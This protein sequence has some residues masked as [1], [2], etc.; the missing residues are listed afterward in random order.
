MTPQRPVLILVCGLF[1]IG[2]GCGLVLLGGQVAGLTPLAVAMILLGSAILIFWL[3]SRSCAHSATCIE[4]DRQNPS[5]T[6]PGVWYP[7]ALLGIGAA[8]MI[9]LLIWTKILR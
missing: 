9:W 5:P 1:S 3:R 8:L 6:L 2:L 4:N 7:Y